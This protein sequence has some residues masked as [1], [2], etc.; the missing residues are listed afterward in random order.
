MS[1]RYWT[2]EQI[3][4]IIK[5]YQDGTSQG[6]LA[7]VYDCSRTAINTVLKNNNVHIRTMKE[8]NSKI[9]EEEVILSIIKEYVI[10]K[11]SLYV[12]AKEF[13]LS[14]D[15]ITSVLK[16]HGIKLRTYA[17][18]KDL[19]RVYTID[20]NFFKTQ[21]HDMA[22]LLGFLAADGNISLKENAIFIE[23]HEQDKDLLEDFRKITNNSRPLSFYNHH[24]EDCKD[25][26][27]V[28]FA[29]WSREWKKDLA[30]YNIVP[31]KTFILQPPTF[32]N[33]E[34][35]SSYI[36]G[37]FDSDGSI[38]F[39]ESK[40]SYC[41]QISAASKYI[42]DWI[43]GVLSN[44]YGIIG[45]FHIGRAPKG[46][47]MYTLTY[48]SQTAIQDFYKI[49]YLDKSSSICLKRKKEKFEKAITLIKS[50][51]TRL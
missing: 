15:K 13:H 40:D 31:Q 20:D 19:S 27:A 32:L 2:E 25:T 21:S 42:I 3:D 44:Q 6:R 18:A 46:T 34:Y 30:V 5:K 17:E 36:K 50:K 7:E 16:E 47:P 45:G 51:S 10:N 23:V 41:V 43:R 14:Q 12:L 11:K 39:N 33:R 48:G 37:F 28:K 38:Y 26:P 4:E 22:Y 24:H 29:T 35:Y 1:R 9:L 8:T 49:W